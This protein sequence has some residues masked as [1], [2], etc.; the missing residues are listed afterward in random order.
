M[1]LTMNLTKE[2]RKNLYLAIRQFV[3]FVV[4]F[5]FVGCIFLLAKRFG[6]KTFAENGVVENIQFTLL[7]LSSMSFLYCAFVEKK[8]REMSLFFALITLLAACRELD[9]FLDA[10]I[11]LVSWKF[12]YLFVFAAIIYAYL[13]LKHHIKSVLKFFGIPSFYIMC[14]AVVIILL[15]AQCIGHRPLI[16]AAFGGHFGRYEEAV[17][18]EFFEEVLE[19]V[20]YFLILLSSIEYNI[21]AKDVK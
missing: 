2:E 21:N 9:K 10:K 1:G 11:P 20:G 19:V 4:I 16:S 12:A 15:V 14:A 7:L 6:N 5:A 17:I 3:Y 18:K 13:N 8:W